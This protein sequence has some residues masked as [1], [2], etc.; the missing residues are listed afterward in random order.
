MCWISTD[1]YL[2]NRGMRL[3]FRHRLLWVRSILGSYIAFSSGFAKWQVPYSYHHTTEVS[4][5]FKLLHLILITTSLD[6]ICSYS[7]YSRLP[8]H[9]WVSILWSCV[10]VMRAPRRVNPSNIPWPPVWIVMIPLPGIW[11]ART[12]SELLPCTWLSYKRNR[13]EEGMVE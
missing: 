2:D 11:R 13:Y 7:E 6:S 12:V 4:N 9:G 5:S 1:G 8:S 10:A 3:A